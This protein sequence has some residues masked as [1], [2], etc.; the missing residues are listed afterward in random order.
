M[1]P[2]RACPFCGTQ[3]TPEPEGP[4]TMTRETGTDLWSVD[5][6]HCGAQGPTEPTEAFA[7]ERW[8]LR[9]GD[10]VIEP[11]LRAVIS[12]LN[13]D[14][15]IA[16]DRITELLEANNGYQQGARDERQRANIYREALLALAN[17][18][19]L[20]SEDLR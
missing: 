6:L 7:R 10:A 5:C 13:A 16:R 18:V 9:H 1:T 2:F 19:K 12:R 8:N 17:G 3:D 20:L 4:L 14:L 11:E 15:S